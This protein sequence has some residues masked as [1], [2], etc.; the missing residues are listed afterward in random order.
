VAAVFVHQNA[1]K[2]LVEVSKII[3]AVISLAS[4]TSIFNYIENDNDTKLKE[5]HFWFRI[6]Q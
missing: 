1:S 4:G 6:L 5:K 2:S 3:S